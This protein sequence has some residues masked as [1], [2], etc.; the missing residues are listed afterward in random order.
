MI[1]LLASILFMSLMATTFRAASERQANA[2]GLAVV[3]RMVTGIIALVLGL[4]LL[5]IEQFQTLWRDIGLLACVAAVCYWLAGFTALKAVETGHLGIT[6]TINRLSMV[7]PTVASIFYWHEIPLS[8]VNVPLLMRASGMALAV[9][10]LVLMG[11][12]RIR[13]KRLNLDLQ[14]PVPP[15]HN[16]R[17]WGLWLACAFLSQGGWEV[18]LRATRAMETDTERAFFMGM[19]FFLAGLFSLP[20]LGVFRPRI[21]RTELKFGFLIA[22]CAGTASATRPWALRDLPGVIVFPVTTVSVT[23]LV[24]AAGILLWRERIGP[25]G[26]AG[27]V[28]AV[29]GIILL[30]MPVPT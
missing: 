14:V 30:T 21:G 7:I 10:T 11:I 28:V 17:T 8:P 26:I 20:V 2:L 18:T 15:H 12:D 5:D 9:V 4:I 3:F 25:W 1:Y 23:L 29:L 22:F 13:E 16:T 24:I 19:V 27:M 6:W